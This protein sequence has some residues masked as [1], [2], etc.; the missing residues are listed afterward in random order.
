[1]K[2]TEIGPLPDD[3][4]IAAVGEVAQV[5]G[6]KRIPKGRRLTEHPTSHPYLRVSDMRMG[7]IDEADLTYVPD[8]VFPSIQRYRISKDDIFISVAGTLG[9]VGKIPPALDGANLTENADRLTAITCD[10][11]YLLHAL[12]SDR[13]QQVIDAERTVGAQPKL[14][15]YRIRTFKI[16]LPPTAEEQRRIARV[17]EDFDALLQKLEVEL[18]KRRN[19]KEAVAQQ[20]VLGRTRLPGFEGHPWDT[21]ALDDVTRR[22][23]GVWGEDRL[24]RSHPR[25]LEIVGV[26]D[27]TRDG[28]LT[29]TSRRYLTEREFAAASSTKGDVLFAASGEPG[30]VWLNDGSRVIGA[31]NFMRILEPLPDRA[32]GPFLYYALQSHLAKVTLAGSTASS[33]IANVQAGF[34]RQSWL[35]LPRLPEQKAIAQVL[36]DLDAGLLARE[37]RADKV[38]Q[39]RLGAAQEL[40]SGR[41]RLGRDGGRA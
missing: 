38:R 36:L 12:M 41:V 34:F 21:V 10:R 19:L 30:K 13:I 17:L 16:G 14:A 6:G 5:K 8:D 39:L 9:L 3:W 28:R 35:P 24:S 23:P 25:M 37:A 22:R 18:V 4:T 15:I 26:G 27:V 20:L 1:M 7:A 40:L 29:G 31:A 33:V 2:D 32:W 11:D